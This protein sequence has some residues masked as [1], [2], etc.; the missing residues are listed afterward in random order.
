MVY[1]IA[2]TQYRK[3]ISFF[4][5]SNLPPFNI[6]K[7]KMDTSFDVHFEK[8]EERGYFIL[9]PNSFARAI[10]PSIKALVS[11]LQTTI[12]LS[13]SFMMSASLKK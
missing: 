6:D 9:Y 13:L 4:N 12:F 7:I 10:I 8:Q 3:P 5:V 11:W 2:P 1:F